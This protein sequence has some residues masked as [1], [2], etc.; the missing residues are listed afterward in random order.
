M[1]SL[2]I[3]NSYTVGNMKSF[4]L[5]WSGILSH[6]TRK[7]AVPERGHLLK[8]L[9]P[10][11]NIEGHAT[12]VRDLTEVVNNDDMLNIALTGSYGAGKSSILRD[13]KES[14]EKHGHKNKNKVIQ[15]SFS[16]LGANIQGYINSSGADEHERLNNLTNL[17]QKEIVKQILFKEKYKNIPY[18]K[19]KR[20]ASP[21]L[22]IVLL[23]ASL[24]SGIMLGALLV[25]GWLD[26]FFKYVSLTNLTWQTAFCVDLFITMAA[27]IAVFFLTVSG[28]IKI[29]KIGASSLSLSLAGNV[30]YFDEYLDE[31]IYF[32]EA[33]RYNVV[34][35]EDI[36]RF[37]SL[38]IFETLRQLNTI[39][40]NSEQ[41]GRPITFI[42]AI[43]DSIFAKKVVDTKI[44]HKERSA[45]RTKFFDVIIPVVP[46]IT[47][48]SSQD[49][50]LEAF[51][52]EYRDV[53][54]G[55][56]SVISK[57]ITD[58]RLVINI[59]NEFLIFKDK[60]VLDD[61]GLS[62]D[63][64]FAVVAYKNWNLEEFEKV[65]DG[66]SS[67]DKVIAAQSRYVDQRIQKINTEIR[68][69]RGALQSINT[70]A[71][72]SEE[73]GGALN[74]YISNVLRQVQ[75][76]AQSYSLNSQSYDLEDFAS[77]EFWDS[78]IKA[79][80]SNTLI[81]TYRASSGYTQNLTLGTADIQAI[82][83]DTLDKSLWDKKAAEDLNS[84]IGVLRA[85]AN[86]LPYMSIK[87]L[88]DTSQE[89]RTIVTELDNGSVIA[90]KVG[91]EL[92]KAGFIDTEFVHYTSLY[93]STTMSL[94]AR[95][96]WLN[97][98]R[99]NKQSFHH[100]FESDSD[101]KALLDKAGNTYLSDKSMYNIAIVDYL[102]K[103][104]DTKMV[105]IIKNLA[106]GKEN[107]LKFINAYVKEGAQVSNFIQLLAVEWDGV[108]TYIADNTEMDTKKKG[109]FV[110]LALVAGS[111]NIR[112]KVNP[113]VRTFIENNVT[114]IQVLSNKDEDNSEVDDACRLLMNFGIEFEIFDNLNN[115][116]QE[117]VKDYGLY[118]VNETNLAF[119]LGN[120]RVPLDTIKRTN[121]YVYSHL[122]GHL[123]EYTDLFQNRKDSEFTL[124]GEEGYESVI[125]EV[126]KISTDSLDII[127]ANA[128]LSNCVVE[129]IN[130]L[131]SDTWTLLIENIILSNTLSNVLTYF[132]QSHADKTVIS[133]T[134][135]NY[136][137]A[138]GTIVLDK[139]YAEYNAASIKA[140]MLAVVNS[141]KVKTGVT[142]D[143]V[144]DCYT[145]DYIDIADIKPQN[146]KLY[147]LLLSKD[148]IEDTQ[149]NFEAIRNLS[150]ET[151]SAYI[152]HSQKFL[153]YIAALAL[154]SDE[155]NSI[156]DDTSIPDTVN[157]Y[158]VDNIT[159]YESELS[160]HSAAHFANFALA[161]SKVLSAES[162]KIIIDGANQETSVR[163][164][165]LAIHNLTSSDMLTLLPVVGGE[166]TKLSK[167]NKRPAFANTDYNLSL[168]T[169]LKELGLVSSYELKD[170]ETMIK[171]V[172]KRL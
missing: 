131:S 34:I 130:K 128:D 42:Y 83:G 115:P 46:F 16:S 79:A 122:L 116:A 151:K 5:I 102:L 156:A 104:E 8:S 138:V 30:S 67:I 80:D 62:L 81:V 44:N 59:Y 141:P 31:I 106:G 134:L 47:N 107:D 121:E 23:S 25:G 170:N 97:N 66:N 73:Y 49:Y 78:V 169:R 86:Q 9:R 92:I 89:F 172:M 48:V 140:F 162:L 69:K 35:F 168:I 126:S 91:W 167:S 39:L 72:R 125:D 146:G 15:L 161:K 24:L 105:N 112:Y 21:R 82:T 132:E 144:H 148:C 76:V 135:A 103:N 88:L 142:V 111:K 51:D 43:K 6:L 70:I 58:M 56:A 113:A 90:D 71:E 32:F 11:K 137:N 108:F 149:A 147:G 85:E 33:A 65:K 119:I 129:D 96:F 123:Q 124:A 99:L 120:A 57:Y 2:L 3:T 118:A 74:D 26:S 38:Y 77:E 75:G 98:I 93:H 159:Q 14:T 143:I 68:N 171:V 52:P 136:L 163:L 164:I 94:K 29:D 50:L 100:K 155:L 53:I 27:L 36:D 166:Y 55:P 133:D 1:L 41:I 114:N 150:W 139:D 160:V 7:K 18:S 101:I 19:Y 109:H 154:T 17:I 117:A 157:E 40:N 12:Y 54:K 45:N 60:V 152:A 61:S 84:E 13:F 95:S 110:S 158:I 127:L 145:E 87:E 63:K 22:P 37:E 64:L 165:G 4:K 28:K 10:A 153:E 20:V